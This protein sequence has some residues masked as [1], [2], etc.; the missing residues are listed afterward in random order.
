MTV[1]FKTRCK[2]FAVFYLF[3]LWNF[4]WFQCKLLSRVSFFYV[5]TKAT[6]KIISV[7]EPKQ[8]YYVPWANKSAGS[9][10]I[11]VVAYFF[12]FL[13]CNATCKTFIMVY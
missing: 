5:F 1:P 7:S 4:R 12:S 2:S 6:N 10:R 13:R 11:F 3:Y 9:Y 8:L